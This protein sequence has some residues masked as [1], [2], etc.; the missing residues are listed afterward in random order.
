L[1]FVRLLRDGQIGL[2]LGISQGLIAGVSVG[3]VVVL[4]VGFSG[5]QSK[6]QEPT[7]LA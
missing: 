7:D 1:D 4:A 6:Q 3:A 2:G 5:R